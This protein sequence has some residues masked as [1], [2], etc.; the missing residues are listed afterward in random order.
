MGGVDQTLAQGDEVQL[1]A[2]LDQDGELKAQYER[3][4]RAVKL[5]REQPREKAP[6]A[7]ASVLMRRVRRRRGLARS[8]TLTANYRFPVEVVIPLLLAALVALFLLISSP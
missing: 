8:A 2:E 6:A 7:L 4:Q 5:L 3:Y 1:K